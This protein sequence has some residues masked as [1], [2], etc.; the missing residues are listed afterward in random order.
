MRRIVAGGMF[1]GTELQTACFAW[2]YEAAS[3]RHLVGLP[4]ML[5][6][7]GT[8]CLIY[9]NGFSL[10]VAK[11]SESLQ[12]PTSDLIWK[13]GIKHLS[14]LNL[15][16]PSHRDISGGSSLKVSKSPVMVSRVSLIRAAI[17]RYSIPTLDFPGL[18]HY[19]T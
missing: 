6:I 3:R 18:R 12:R 9:L 8:R 5:P 16:I 2:T 13:Y 11:V 4:L 14:L 17:P 10:E 7:F 15:L 19:H 1:S